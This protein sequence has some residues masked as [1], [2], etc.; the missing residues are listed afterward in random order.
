MDK[1]AKK[2]ERTRAQILSTALELFCSQ[3][4]EAT[5][6]R[7]IAEKAGM[8]LGAAYYYFRSKDD[9]V[10]AFY[11]E[12]AIEAQLKN[13]ELLRES[14]DFKKRFRSII[15]FKLSQLQNHRH[16]VKVIARQAADLENPLSPFSKENKALR[17]QAIAV[18]EDAIE[19]SSLKASK[20]LRPHLAKLL[21]LYQMAVLFFWAN[22]KSKN[23]SRTTKLIDQTLGLLIRLLQI[24]SLP[25]MGP[26]NQAVL[27][28]L[29]VIE[30]ES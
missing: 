21:W 18:I 22:D 2:S 26:V 25:L 1:A 30:G 4:F 17:E 11:A 10:L 15:D 6:M 20:T 29:R 8:S 7:Q 19:G 14:K 28:T 16:L 9:L 24:S 23:E 5:T 3:G 27:K 12:T 13:Q